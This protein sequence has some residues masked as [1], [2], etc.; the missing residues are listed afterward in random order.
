MFFRNLLLKMSETENINSPIKSLLLAFSACPY[1]IA[2]ERQ[3]ELKALV[4]RHDVRLNIDTVKK[5]F[6]IEAWPNFKLVFF[7]LATLE[8]LWAYAYGYYTLLE[9]QR[10]V[11]KG[12]EVDLTTHSTGV[13]AKELLAWA[14]K[15]EHS[16][17]HMPWPDGA[18]T[19]DSLNDPNVEPANE[20]FLVMCAWIFLHEIAHIELHGKPVDSTAPVENASDSESESE[21]SIR[22]EFEADA[23]SSHWILDRWTEFKGDDENVFIKRTL[24]IAFAISALTGL[25]LYR[26]SGKKGT[27]PSVPDRLLAFL[28]EFIPETDAQK[29]SKKE[30][31][32]LAAIVVLSANLIHHKS[33][34]P[35][36]VHNTFRDFVVYSKL[37]FPA[38]TCH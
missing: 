21:Q 24:G 30:I 25:D 18:P 6:H 34:D 28:D 22:Q 32:W 11:G 19:P 31:A 5:E 17:V 29:A 4:D 35:K 12:V 16:E 23:W 9:I 26:K 36:K 14:V 2:P 27:H 1:K 10:D 38:V 15:N 20:I 8:R 37:F 33:Y 3:D 13:K 7:G